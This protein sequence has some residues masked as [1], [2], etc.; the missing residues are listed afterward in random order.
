MP[1]KPPQNRSC[2]NP[3]CILH[4]QFGKQNVLR[5]RCFTRGCGPFHDIL[6]V[7]SPA[8]PDQRFMLS[9]ARK[10]ILFGKNSK[11]FRVAALFSSHRPFPLFVQMPMICY[12]SGF[13]AQQTVSG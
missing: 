3:N 2:P 6:G 10:G 7:F 1:R 9:D 4:G 8:L 11:S 5:Y 13:H 12:L